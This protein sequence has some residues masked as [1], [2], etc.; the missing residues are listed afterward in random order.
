MA[1][2]KITNKVA[3]TVVKAKRVFK[4]SRVEKGKGTAR[5]SGKAMAEARGK[6]RVGILYGKDFDP[7]KVGTQSR[8]YPQKCRRIKGYGGQFHIDVNAGLKMAQLHPDIFEIDPVTAKEITPAR[9]RRNHINFDFWYDPM[10]AR[11]EAV[12]MPGGKQHV[13]NVDICHQDPNCRIFPD[14]HFLHWIAYKPT[15][16]RACEKAGVPIIP[17]IYVENGFRTKPVLKAVQARGWDKFFVKVGYAA[18]FG[19][20]AING[21]TADFVAHPEI[22]DEFGK[23]NEMHKCFLVQPYMLKPDGE[24]FDEVRNFFV[25]GVW[26]TAIFTHG[27]DGSNAGYYR[28]PQGKRL[29]AVREVAMKAYEVV[30]KVAKWRGKSMDALLSRIDVG[31]IPDKRAKYGFQVFVN[32]I[33]P[34]SATWLARY[35]PDDCSEVMGKATV[36]KARQ[37]LSMALAEGQGLPNAAMVRRNLELLEQR[38]Q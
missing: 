29:E 20:G 25:N 37:L 24:V 27:T 14:Y 16:L 28:E 31:V 9:L 3:K 13:T 19:E 30:R 10:V 4:A 33:E 23:Q 26:H 18:F 21:K 38:L 6:I 11:R 5:S 17:T 35:W 7:V 36:E 34:E 22:L 15:Y 8:F 2:K 1:Q 12:N 32:E